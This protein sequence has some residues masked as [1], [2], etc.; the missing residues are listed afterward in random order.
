M[1][2]AAITKAAINIQ[3]GSQLVIDPPAHPLIQP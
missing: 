2:A 3:T 1:I